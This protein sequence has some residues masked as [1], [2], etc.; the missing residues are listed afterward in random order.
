MTFPSRI[1][2]LLPSSRETS[3]PI[4]TGTSLVILTNSSYKQ[5]S[6]LIISEGRLVYRN[7]YQNKFITM[8]EKDIP[9]VP[10]S[11][12][13]HLDPLSNTPPSLQLCVERLRAFF[14]ERPISTRRAIFNTYLARHGL[15]IT[16]DSDNW[17]PLYRFALPYVCYMFRSGPFRDAYVL[18]GID[19]RKE[20]KWS[21]YQT[22]AFNFRTGKWR[23]KSVVQDDMKRLWEM[24]NSHV[25]TG[26]D[27]DTQVLLY[28]FVD[29]EDPM[30]RK[31]IDESPLRE[32]FHV[33]S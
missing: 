20:A 15:G 5:N 17:R 2:C 8:V 29:I 18:F 26:K 9:I 32:K 31:L 23:N 7:I 1:S 11:P 13:S 22:A 25:F 27:V 30:L 19:P 14:A 3:S 4:T 28:C 33:S 10:S 6:G 21:N 12:S 16:H 24:R